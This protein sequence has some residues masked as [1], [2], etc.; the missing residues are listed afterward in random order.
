M[1]MQ[2]LSREFALCSTVGDEVTIVLNGYNFDAIDM[3]G[4]PSGQ[5][6]SFRLVDGEF[7][8]LHKSWSQ[9]A[10]LWL[11]TDQGR[12]FPVRIAALP[13]DALSFGLME[14]V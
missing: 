11:R 1:A 10:I 14:F 5:M 13:T 8:S 7:R 6:R 12:E 9:Q 2:K 3:H 4:A